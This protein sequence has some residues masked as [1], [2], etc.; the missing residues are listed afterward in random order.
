[1][2][3]PQTCDL[4]PELRAIPPR[5]W[6]TSIILAEAIQCRGKARRNRMLRILETCFV[7]FFSFNPIRQIGKNR[8]PNIAFTPNGPLVYRFDR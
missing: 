1:M 3:V 4:G 2:S 7:Q 6:R 5:S 8:P